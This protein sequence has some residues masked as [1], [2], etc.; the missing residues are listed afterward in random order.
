[1]NLRRTRMVVALVILGG[2]AAAWLGLRG[3]WMGAQAGVRTVETTDDRRYEGRIYPAGDLSFL[4]QGD[5]VAVLLTADQIRAVDGVAVD[6]GPLPLAEHPP[7]V[8]ETVETV[9][10]EGD[11]E[12]RSIIRGRNHAEAAMTNTWFRM[13]AEERRRQRE[14]RILDAYGNEL[15]MRFTPAEDTELVR[16]DVD[17]RRPILPGEEWRFTHVFRDSTTCWQENGEWVFRHVGDYPD[18]RIVTRT[19]AL[20]PGAGIREITPLPTERLRKGDRSIVIWRRLFE[21]GEEQPWEI[22]YALP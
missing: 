13:T 14:Y 7:F 11:V 17:L 8:Q 1:M 15:A 9:D 19:V 22:R 12:V 5:S 6:E 3:G 20:P 2:L 21:P 16:V 4:V 10:R 18:R